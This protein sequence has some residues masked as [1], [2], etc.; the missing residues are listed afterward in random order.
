MYNLISNNRLIWG[1]IAYSKSRFEDALQELEIAYTLPYSTDDAIIIDKT[2]GIY[3]TLP[4]ITPDNDPLFE[5]LVGPTFTIVDNKVQYTYTKQDRNL[6]H[7][8]S[9]M[10]SMIAAT[11]WG[12]ET[13]GITILV[14]GNSVW[15]PTAKGDRDIFLQSMQLGIDNVKTGDL[16]PWVKNNQFLLLN[17]SLSVFEGKSNS[18]QDH[19]LDYTDKLIKDIS[20]KTDHVIFLL[21]GNNAQSKSKFIDNKKH[22]IIKGIHPSPLSAYRGFFGSGIFDKLDDEYEKLFNKEIKWDL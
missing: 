5:Q 1:P 13:A 4:I 22:I 18:H 11:R 10:Q 7:I 17:S 9:D 12:Y 19:W 3:P 2:T 20:D 14:Q 15:I 16:T 6:D 21:L 8:K